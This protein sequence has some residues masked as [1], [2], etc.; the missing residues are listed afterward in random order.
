ML[1]WVLAT[2]SETMMVSLNELGE[3]IRI[4]SDIEI[5]LEYDLN[6]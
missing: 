6:L 3:G 5:N 4:S 2:I 1:T